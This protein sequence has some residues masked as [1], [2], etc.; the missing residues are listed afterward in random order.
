MR[1]ETYIMLLFSITIVF[2]FLGYQSPLMQ[3]L[4]NQGCTQAQIDAAALAGT[5]LNCSI[6]PASFL[7]VLA[8]NMTSDNAIAALLGIAV[9]GA[10]VLLSGFG[11]IYIIPLMM[12]LAFMNYVVFPIS[13]IFDPLLPAIIKY[14]LIVFF[15]L[16][17]ILSIVSFT[18][19]NV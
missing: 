4:T 17:M 8:S 14:P 7:T 3:V 10:A 19:G 5:S 11:A 6:T 13:F 18:R 15:N 9:I 1:L 2:Y 16:L 12:L